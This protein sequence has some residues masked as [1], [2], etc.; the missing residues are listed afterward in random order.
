MD[1]TILQIPIANVVLMFTI[2]IVTCFANLA[3]NRQSWL[4]RLAEIAVNN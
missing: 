3:W 1:L 2:F 4:V